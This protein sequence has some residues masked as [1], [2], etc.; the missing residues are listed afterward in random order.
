MDIAP[1]TKVMIRLS[2]TY[3]LAVRVKKP[4]QTH[5]YVRQ[6][7]LKYNILCIAHVSGIILTKILGKD[8][9]AMTKVDH[10]YRQCITTPHI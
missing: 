8:H 3:Q 9:P 2:S 5:Q 4:G 10:L 7:L 1:N 6:S